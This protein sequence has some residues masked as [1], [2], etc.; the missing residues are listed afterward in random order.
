MAELNQVRMDAAGKAYARI[1]DLKAQRERAGKSDS[2]SPGLIR[3][4][5]SKG[6]G[7]KWWLAE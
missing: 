1:E 7:R 5:S 3:Q 6:Q 4:I 2:E